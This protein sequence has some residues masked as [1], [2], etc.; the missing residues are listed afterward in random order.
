MI[1]IFIFIGWTW[2]FDSLMQPNVSLW[3]VKV[4]RMLWLFSSLDFIIIEFFHLFYVDGV[5]RM[6]KF[7]NIQIPKHADN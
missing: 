1:L 2:K 6:P 4:I 7:F 5:D 3:V